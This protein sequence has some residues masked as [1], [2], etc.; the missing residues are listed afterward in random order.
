MA[1]AV[2]LW[3][4]NLEVVNLGVVSLEAVNLEVVNLEVDL[5]AVSMQ[6]LKTHTGVSHPSFCNFD[7]FLSM[8]YAHTNL[9]NG[10]K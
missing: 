7:D 10:P 4:V 1:G 2:S 8:G 9:G 5:G 6:C 3:V